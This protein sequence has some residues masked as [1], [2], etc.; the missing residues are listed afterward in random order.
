MSELLIPDP[1][2]YQ[3]M[4]S[5]PDRE[6]INRWNSQKRAIMWR[7]RK[8][9]REKMRTIFT[10]ILIGAMC[11]MT[12]FLIGKS[13]FIKEYHRDGQLMAVCC[14]YK[15]D[16]YHLCR[17]V[18]FAPIAVQEKSAVQPIIPSGQIQDSEPSSE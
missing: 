8:Q 14:K 1:S 13:V 15:G 2:E 11:L 6:A 5:G 12:G 16:W 4:D 18:E 9:R 17:R 10:S 7:L 3:D